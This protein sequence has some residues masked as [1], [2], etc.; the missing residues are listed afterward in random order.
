MHSTSIDRTTAGRA[1]RRARRGLRTSVRLALGGIAVVVLGLLAVPTAAADPVVATEP[2]DRQELD[3]AP[4]WVTLAF[5]R[6]VDPGSAK[7]LVLD[8]QG[9]NATVGQLIV[10]GTNVT[11]QLEDGLPRGTYTVR[12]RVVTT[13][14]P[15]GGAY[16]FSYG[17]GSFTDLPDRSWS[18]T[19]DEPPVLR[20]DD[21]NATTSAPPPS[22][23]PRETE[24]GVEVSKGG[25]SGAPTPAPTG[26]ATSAGPSVEPGADPT[27]TPTTVGSSAAAT[28]VASPS[29]TASSGGDGSGAVVV[30]LVAGVLVLA[31]AAGTLVWWRQRRA[32]H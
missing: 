28:P 17:Q 21:P 3:A 32:T 15:F 23:R 20:N 22:P 31:A 30:A 29:P 4:G 2:L 26:A 25:P 6:E 27:A 8:A 18:G 19:D 5:D 24:P 12:Y 9:R 7:V 11:T 16:Q 1:P 10:E 14:E 13:E